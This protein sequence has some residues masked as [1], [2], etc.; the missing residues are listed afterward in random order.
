MVR[1]HVVVD[2]P[3]KKRLTKNYKR[4]LKSWKIRKNPLPIPEENYPPP[5]PTA[6]QDDSSPFS[7]LKLEPGPVLSQVVA[8]CFPNENVQNDQNFY[9]GTYDKW[10]V[11]DGRQLYIA[12]TVSINGVKLIELYDFPS[13]VRKHFWGIFYAVCYHKILVSTFTSDLT[14]SRLAPMFLSLWS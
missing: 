1:L 12:V 4:R 11:G 3:E 9:Y 13:T 14:L 5:L 8:E 2:T 10:G 6:L 7:N